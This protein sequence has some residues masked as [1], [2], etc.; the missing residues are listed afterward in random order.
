MKW[1]SLLSNLKI[2]FLLIFIIAALGNRLG[3]FD[4]VT[5]LNEDTLDDIKY[6]AI[7]FYAIVYIF[8]LKITVRQKDKEITELK[9]Q[10]NS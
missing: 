1:A 10:L 9:S 4:S 5:S 2:V 8:E 7:L 3:W 6:V